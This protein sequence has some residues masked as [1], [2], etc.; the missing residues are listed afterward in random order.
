MSEV[1]LL[2]REGYEKIVA[3]HEELVSIRRREVAEKIKEALSY[4]D[5]SENAEYD[6]AKNEQAELEERINKLENM[7]P[8]AKI[9]DEIESPHDIVSVGT[10][11]KVREIESNEEMDLIIVGSAEADPF[12][13]RI[14]NE[15]RV[16]EALLGKT[17]HQIAEVT[18]PDG[19]IVHYEILAIG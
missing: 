17:V 11:V 7:M 6:A 1:I 18:I 5:I 10:K 16:G 3:E 4:G 2:T 15:S 19:S 12:E 14:S 8:K 13:G 9:I